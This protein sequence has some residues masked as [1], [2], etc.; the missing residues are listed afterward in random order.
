MSPEVPEAAF[1]GGQSGQRGEDLLQD[2]LPVLLIAGEHLNR[3]QNKSQSDN[4]RIQQD[5]QS[6]WSL[7]SVHSLHLEKGGGSFGV[8]VKVLNWGSNL[9]VIFLSLCSMCVYVCVCGS[10]ADRLQR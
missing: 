5:H 8:S 1:A 10:V 4:M 6:V 7:L 9:M 2:E 3:H